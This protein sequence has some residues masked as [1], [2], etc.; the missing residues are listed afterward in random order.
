MSNSGG[1]N[2]LKQIEAEVWLEG[3]EWMRQR[4]QQR[5]QARSDR[6]GAVSPPQPDAADPCEPP[7]SDVGD[8]GR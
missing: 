5:L 4:L 6:L 2:P 7:P 1:S 8:D 3:R